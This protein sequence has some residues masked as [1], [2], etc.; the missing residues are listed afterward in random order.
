MRVY[1]EAKDPNETKDYTF[2]WSPLLASGETVDSHV[3]A[4]VEAAGTASPSQSLAS[5]ISRVWLAGGTHG[6]QAIYT[7]TATTNGGRILEE[8]FGVNV[9]DSVLGPV[10]ETDIERLTREIGELKAQRVNIATGNAI[11]D[12]WRDGRRLRKKAGSLAEINDLIRQLESELVAAQIAAG[13]TPTNRRR[14]IALAYR[15]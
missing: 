2:D 8:A 1:D 12:I 14:P 10:A 7:I 3:V 13:I 4:F 9:V 15:N 11:I 6:E 5:N